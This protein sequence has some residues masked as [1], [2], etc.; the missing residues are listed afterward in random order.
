[1]GQAKFFS[2]AQKAGAAKA[3]TPRKSSTFLNRYQR[4]STIKHATIE[5]MI[6]ITMQD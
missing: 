2:E 1:V 3:A 5:T 4:R 6:E